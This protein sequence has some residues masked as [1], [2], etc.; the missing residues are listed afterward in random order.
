[1]AIYEERLATFTSWPHTRPDPETLATNGFQ[2]VPS[3][4]SPDNVHCTECSTDFNGWRPGINPF[5]WHLKP[6]PPWPQGAHGFHTHYGFRPA[7][8]NP[9]QAMDKSM[10]CAIEHK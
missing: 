9:R 3:K 8:S 7:C 5:A 4:E 2:F 10:G 6:S 1:M